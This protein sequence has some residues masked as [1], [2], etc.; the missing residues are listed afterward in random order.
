MASIVSFDCDF[1]TMGLRRVR[2][3]V[4]GALL[5]GKWEG[6]RFRLSHRAGTGW[7]LA[8]L[9]KPLGDSAYWD[10]ALTEQNGLCIDVGIFETQ[11]AALMIARGF[12]EGKKVWREAYRTNIGIVPAAFVD[13][14]LANKEF[15]YG[16]AP[17]GSHA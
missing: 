16:E 14:S 8:L 9:L 12:L 7:T 17:R 11:T 13:S 2:D 4:S 15:A 10:I 6:D 1:A 3:V 5:A